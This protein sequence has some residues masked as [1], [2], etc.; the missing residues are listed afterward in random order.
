M[1]NFQETDPSK[2]AVGFGGTLNL[3]AGLLFLVLTLVLMSGLWH[4]Q[5]ATNENAELP[6]GYG[7]WVVAFGVGLGSGVSLLAALIPLHLGAGALR[8][9]EF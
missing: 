4:A 1:P 2:I 8:Q 7:A 3:V 9:M 5:T 6:A